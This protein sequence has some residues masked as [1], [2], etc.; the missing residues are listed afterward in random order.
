MLLIIKKQNKSLKI[1]DKQRTLNS[2]HILCQGFQNAESIAQ[3][4]G[5]AFEFTRTKDGLYSRIILCP[6]PVFSFRQEK[7]KNVISIVDFN[8]DYM[9]VCS[10]ILIV[11]FQS[12]LFL[13]KC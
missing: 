10:E 5:I 7:F 1:V 4:Q 13:D 6:S 2:S 8:L 11:S 3:G 12:F 9:Y